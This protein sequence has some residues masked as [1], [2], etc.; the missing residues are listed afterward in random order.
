MLEIR[1]HQHAEGQVHDRVPN[2]KSITHFKKKTPLEKQ[3]HLHVEKKNPLHCS[4]MVN[5]RLTVC[6]GMGGGHH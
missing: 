1:V 5:D 4:F 2:A 6:V 3:N